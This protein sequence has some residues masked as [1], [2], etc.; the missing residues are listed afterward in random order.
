MRMINKMIKN[1][2]EKYGVIGD[3]RPTLTVLEGGL[4]TMEKHGVVKDEEKTKTASTA[5]GKCPSCGS[6]L[7]KE[8]DDH[9][10]HCPQCGTKPFEKKP[11]QV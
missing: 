3:S 7:T 5:K 8:G 6:E 4:S 11:E 9:I 1:N 2:M 10:D